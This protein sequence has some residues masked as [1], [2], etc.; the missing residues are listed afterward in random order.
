MR[1]SGVC[2]PGVKPVSVLL[3]VDMVPPLGCPRERNNLGRFNFLIG[4]LLKQGFYPWAIALGAQ[5]LVQRLGIQP[6]IADG[7]L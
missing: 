2:W 5:G 4:C 3:R 6:C 1:A 7:L